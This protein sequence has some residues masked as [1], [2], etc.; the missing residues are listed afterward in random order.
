MAEILTKKLVHELERGD[1]L[2]QDI[3]HYDDLRKEGLL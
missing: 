2:G 3:G 1:K